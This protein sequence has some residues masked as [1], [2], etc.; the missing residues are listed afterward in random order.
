RAAAAHF[1]HQLVLGDDALHG[2]RPVHRDAPGAGMRAQ[3]EARLGGRVDGHSARAGVC[4]DV[5]RA[6]LF[7]V[8]AA[9]PGVGSNPATDARCAYRAAASVS[10][11]VAFDVIQLHAPRAG[12]RANL[13]SDFRDGDGTRAGLGIH[14]A[15][16]ALHDDVA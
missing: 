12:M 11:H 4:P 6:G 14:G 7:D 5:T 2:H 13:V 1:G 8:N 16:D 9:G 10:I 15:A 3:I